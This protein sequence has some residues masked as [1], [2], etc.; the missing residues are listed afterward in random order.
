ML[1]AMPAS[2]AD[3]ADTAIAKQCPAAAGWMRAHPR[4]HADDAVAGDARRQVT[5]PA[6]RAEFERMSGEDQATR[7]A[8]IAADGKDPAAN[9]ATADADARHLR[10]L[11]Q[12]VATQGFPTVAQ[13]GVAGV[14][15]AWLLVQHADSDPAFQARMLA[16]MEPLVGT[17]GIRAKDLALLTD[18]VLRAQHKPQR[19]G[20]QF[21]MKDGTLRAQPIADAA[22]VDKRRASV[23]LMPL[24][25]YAC[26][27]RVVYGAAPAH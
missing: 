23:G 2:A 10:R 18:R 11:K 26:V 21:Q 27:L 17:G 12:I 4:Q 1:L 13:I 6:L 14:Q 8:M 16:A 24:A 20:S 3:R 15:A 9:K 5:Q 7:E 25:D 19:Y 22:G